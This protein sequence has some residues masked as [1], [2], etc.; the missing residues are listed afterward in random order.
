MLS[1]IRITKDGIIIHFIN[2]VAEVLL[3]IGYVLTA[4]MY[5]MDFQQCDAISSKWKTRTLLS[6]VIVHFFY[7]GLHTA[8]FGRCMV[9]TPFEIMSLIAFTLAV[10]YAILE[11]RTGERGTGVFIITMATVLELTS[12][13]MTKLPT[14][15]LPNPVLSEMAIGLHVS[16]AIFGYAGFALSAMHGIMYLLMYR[17]LKSGS[18]GA[19]Y[20]NLPSLESLER[21]AVMS[22]LV[23]F[24]FLTVSMIIGVAWL[25]RA[26]DNYSYLDPK[27][28]ATALTWLLYGALL[29]ARYVLRVEGSRI[30]KL[31]IWGFAF[32]I[33]SMTIVNGFLS[34]FHRFM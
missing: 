28:I 11:L 22:A 13:I 34:E 15:D 17:E 8:E 7:I 2:S 3:P 18:F 29:F 23:G 31:A 32:A 14:S 33:I 16:F 21:M 4:F 6:T 26:Y 5:A 9:T 19:I 24:I 27:L 10:T 1:G 25:P 20:K 12:A 30:V